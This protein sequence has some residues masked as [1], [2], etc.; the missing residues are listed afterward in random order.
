MNHVVEVVL[1]AVT[2]SCLGLILA[3][4]TR[5]NPTFVAYVPIMVCAV[6]A[7]TVTLVLASK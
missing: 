7:S 6:V 5:R 3:Y 4:L 1:I 2:V